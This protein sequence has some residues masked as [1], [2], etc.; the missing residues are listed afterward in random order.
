MGVMDDSIN[1]D[2]VNKCVSA[3]AAE[4]I[5]NIKEQLKQ[6]GFTGQ[7]LARGIIVVGRGAFLSGFN[8]RLAKETG[9]NV[10][11]GSIS[12]AE[13]RI[14]D[15]RI[16]PVDCVDVLSI[17]RE[18]AKGSTHECLTQPEPEVV[19]EPVEEVP[20]TEPEPEPEIEKPRAQT[21]ALVGILKP[22]EET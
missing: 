14:S 7:Q 2:Q 4:I 13:V 11:S 5:A 8:D 18:A 22:C 1:F 10:R 12:T 16:S 3:R 17:L 15:V 21:L 6:S 19:E 9:M 20:V